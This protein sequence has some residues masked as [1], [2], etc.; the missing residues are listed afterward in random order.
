V[1]SEDKAELT[2]QV[3]ASIEGLNADLDDENQVP[4]KLK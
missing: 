4:Q 2:T 3:D 1:S